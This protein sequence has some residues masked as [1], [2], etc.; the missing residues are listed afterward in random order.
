MK[1]A[2]AAAGTFREDA[3]GT[4]SVGAVALPEVCMTQQLQ[5]APS[6]THLIQSLQRTVNDPRDESV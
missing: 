6:D 4:L 5:A 1:M 3:D 2:V